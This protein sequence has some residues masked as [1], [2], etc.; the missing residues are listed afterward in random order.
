MD[1]HYHLM[2]KIGIV[3]LHK[4]MQRI[5]RS[6]KCANQYEKVGNA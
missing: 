6:I 4:I 2:V 3:D 1:N 5:A